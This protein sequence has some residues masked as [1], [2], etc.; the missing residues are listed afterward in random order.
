MA[1]TSAASASASSSAS[2]AA[3]SS[4]VGVVQLEGLAMLKI[5]KHCKE[6][7]PDLV[8]GQLL[9]LDVE[10]RLEV[11]T[12]RCGD[13]KL[14]ANTGSVLFRRIRSLCVCFLSVSLVEHSC[15]FFLSVFATHLLPCLFADQVH[16]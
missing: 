10:S 1:S 3:S 8:T 15:F 4:H 7:L 6:S 13:C 2:A 9:G 11:G 14:N 12:L 16:V 5:V